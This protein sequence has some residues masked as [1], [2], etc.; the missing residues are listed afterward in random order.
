M[1][2]PRAAKMVPRVVEMV[3]RVIVKGWDPGRGVSKAVHVTGNLEA[4]PRL[5]YV[6]IP[7]VPEI[8]P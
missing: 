8:V 2:P 1:E 7:Q 5:R 6:R 4:I 3:P